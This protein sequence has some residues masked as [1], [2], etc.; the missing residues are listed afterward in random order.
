MIDSGLYL[1]GDEKY[2]KLLYTIIDNGFEIYIGE[3]SEYPAYRQTEPFIPNPDINYEENAKLF[4][5]SLAIKNDLI[6]KEEADQLYASAEDVTSL[7]SDI[8]YLMLLNDADSATEEET[9]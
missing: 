5:E 8:D 1:H 7:R 2:G 3:N 6:D 4:C 9:K